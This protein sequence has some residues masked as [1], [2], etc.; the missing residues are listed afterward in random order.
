M[1]LML[2]VG[3]EPAFSQSSI[4]LNAQLREINA[5]AERIKKYKLPQIPQVPV[6]HPEKDLS[7]EEMRFKG[8]TQAQIDS[9]KRTDKDKQ[10]FYTNFLTELSRIADYERQSDSLEI[11]LEEDIVTLY[12][13]YD[14]ITTRNDSCSAFMKYHMFPM[15]GSISNQALYNKLFG[16]NGLYKPTLGSLKERLHEKINVYM[17]A[18]KLDTINIASD[19]INSLIALADSLDSNTNHSLII[20][21]AEYFASCNSAYKELSAMRDLHGTPEE[22]EPISVLIKLIEMRLKIDEKWMNILHFPNI[23]STLLWEIKT[24]MRPGKKMGRYNEVTLQKQLKMWIKTKTKEL[25][26]RI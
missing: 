12:S 8:K 20:L 18:H 14:D 17:I 6:L 22:L 3:T 2:L 15:S 24:M 25:K 5:I 13:F 1:F 11:P 16:K 4:M 9:I 21:S 7:P 19:D 26:F 10:A 23:D